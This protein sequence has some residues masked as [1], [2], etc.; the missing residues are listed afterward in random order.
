MPFLRELSLSIFGRLFHIYL[1]GYFICKFSIFQ[2]FASHQV[3]SL[4]LSVPFRIERLKGLC[5]SANLYTTKYM[6]K[7]LCFFLFLS[8]DNGKIS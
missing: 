8:K 3:V 1:V 5:L 2:L 4:Y 6:Y 7:V